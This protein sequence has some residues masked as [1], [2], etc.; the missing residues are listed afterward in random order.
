MF[1]SP[2]F[3]SHPRRFRCNRYIYP[4]LSRRS[5][6]LSIGVNLS[7]D[8]RCNF[9][10]VYC[11][12]VCR[13]PDLDS[14]TAADAPGASLPPAVAPPLRQPSVGSPDAIAPEADELKDPSSGAPLGGACDESPGEGIDVRLL[15][16]ELDEIL[17][18]AVDGSIFDEPP[19]R[20]V[21]PGL[22]RLNDIALSGDG[23]PTL[24]PSF[25]EVVDICAE[26]R[27]HYA[28]DDVKIVLITNASLLDR[29]RVAAALE[30]LDRN[31][32]E[33]WAK[34]DAGTEGYYRRVARTNVPWSRILENL[35]GAARVRPI[36][37]QTLLA[38]LAGEPPPEEELEAY[39][40]R[41]GE[42]VAGGGRIKLVQIH[43]V[44]RPPAE[45][46][47]APLAIFEL[48]AIARRVRAA[49]GLDVATFPGARAVDP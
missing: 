27:R 23:E 49:T 26:A 7:P 25:P 22:R 33:I 21:P 16:E 36:V 40:R 35:R 12:V 17:A 32:G 43:T 19:F 11:Q 14:P 2:L 24:S 42:I 28:L 45:T 39:C 10:C 6:G 20:D 29:P 9:D 30:V 31:G 15:R 38:R 44:A 5:G 18:R 4:V 34:L 41:L 48:E 8:A 47:V 3:G 46:W 37:V 1:S 13:R